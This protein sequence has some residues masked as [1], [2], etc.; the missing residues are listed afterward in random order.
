MAN[1]SWW[2]DSPGTPRFLAVSHD[3]RHESFGTADEHVAVGE[4]GNQMA[5]RPLVDRCPFPV[6]DQFVEH[7]PAALDQLA[8]LCAST[9]SAAAGGPQDDDRRWRRGRSSSSDRS[10]VTPIPAATSRARGRRW[11][12]RVKVAVWTLD[13]DPRARPQPRQGSRVITDR[14]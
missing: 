3:V 4:V 1:A 8:D 11:A 12:C 14:P 6:A 7:A 2:M 10:A 9:R 5:Q 13:G